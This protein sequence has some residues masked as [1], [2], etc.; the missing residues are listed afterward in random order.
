MMDKK[1]RN[2]LIFGILIISIS[3]SYYLVF[4]PTPTTQLQ[5]QNQKT[6]FDACFDKCTGN[7]RDGFVCVNI[8]GRHYN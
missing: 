4:K 1:L 5:I 6:E 3:I 2:T 8:C 7:G